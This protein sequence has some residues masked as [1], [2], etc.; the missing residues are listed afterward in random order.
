MY[1]LGVGGCSLVL[2]IR[3]LQVAD[4]VKQSATLD[5]ISNL[6]NPDK[7]YVLWRTC[8]LENYVNTA[9]LQVG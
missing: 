1:L 8:T 4:E 3:S 6:N 9:Y 2:G 5:N 7:I